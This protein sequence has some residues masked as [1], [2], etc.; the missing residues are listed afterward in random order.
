MMGIEPTRAWFTARSVNHFTTFAIGSVF[1]ILILADIVK[2]N[3]RGISKS[4]F[5]SK[6]IGNSRRLTKVLNGESPIF[7]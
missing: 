3:Y 2:N 6:R 1:I 7:S 4:F 5:A